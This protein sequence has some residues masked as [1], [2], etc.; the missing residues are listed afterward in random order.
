MI[1]RNVIA[2]AIYCC[3]ISAV[4]AAGAVLD[5]VARDFKPLSGYLVMPV[6]DEYLVD[7][8]AGKGLVA[9]DLLA[10]IEK[11]KKVIHPVT[12]KV[13]GTLD[14]VKGV[15]Q[16]VRVKTGYSYARTIG[17]AKD[18]KAGDLVRRYTD[19]PAL[20]WDY[21]GRGEEVYARLKK[22]LP[23]LEWQDY[24]VAQAGRPD[25]PGA[26][27]MQEATLIFVLDGSG[28]SVHDGSYQ[29]LHAYPPPE[30]VKT[31]G[32]ERFVPVPSSPSL[33]A[34]AQAEAGKELVR[35]EHAAVTDNRQPEGARAVYPGFHTLGALPEGTLMAA[36]VR[37]GQKLLLA[38]TDG[39]AI[40]I[41][42]VGAT[43]VPL[44]HLSPERPA[45]LLALHWWQPKVDGPLYLA[46]TSSVEVNQAVTSTT[47]HTVSGL[48][49]QLQ[50][51]RL[52]PVVDD[53][54]YLLGSFDRDGD[55]VNETLLGQNFDRDTFFGQNIKELY[56]ADGGVATRATGLTL[57]RNFPV[58]GSLLADLT[59]D[60]HEEAISVRHRV[61]SI[62]DGR[63]VLYESPRQMGG[64]LSGMTFAR[65]PGAVD[66]LLA[67]EPLEV[68]PVAAD[69]DGDGRLELVAIAAEGSLLRAPGLGASVDKAWLVVMRYG[70]GAFI[71]GSLGDELDGPIQG[72]TV[73]GNRV[74]LV[75][76]QAGS[77]LGKTGK[78]YLMSLPLKQ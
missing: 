57:P 54:P 28:L 6:G 59:G 37:Q 41:F 3:I 38:C 34:N 61:L 66:E 45:S 30:A 8:D 16:I 4:P 10:V 72:L 44:A 56:L 23:Q 42:T 35:W 11:G 48:I 51:N 27:A 19:L 33:A 31:T 52:V 78:S 2:A 26:L 46:V 67:T 12:G 5:D 24:G 71:R 74:L 9:G 73:D 22:F 15:L 21:T 17:K 68:S 18:L 53:L 39:K 70:N 7:L 50:K 40:Q 58:Q 36:F 14:Q 69:L 13:L 20:F 55:G 60:G 76:T 65:N 63:K 47:P 1:L 32:V 77:F 25:K 49:F 75:G 64:S 29:A 43:L 62:A